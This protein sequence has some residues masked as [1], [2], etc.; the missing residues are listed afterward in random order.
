MMYSDIQS[1]LPLTEAT[2]LIMMSL[3]N[4]PQHGYGIMKDVEAVSEGR[5]IFSTGTLYGALKRLLDQG[6]IVRF[7]D[8]SESNSGRNRKTYQLTDQ[9]RRILLGEI[10]RLET[11]TRLSRLRLKE[12][13]S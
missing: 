3:I 2:F 1:D 6:W 11:L 12:N 4:E 8:D 7:E 9:G 10:D 13:S 5:V